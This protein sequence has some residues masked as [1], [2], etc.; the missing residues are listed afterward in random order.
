VKIRLRRVRRV[1]PSSREEDEK[2]RRRIV[3][4]ALV[5]A[6]P[7]RRLFVSNFRHNR[8]RVER[9]VSRSA[10][11]LTSDNRH[12]ITNVFLRANVS[13]TSCH[14]HALHSY[15]RYVFFPL[16]T[17]TTY[18]QLGRFDKSESNRFLR[19]RHVCAAW[20]RTSGHC[21]KQ[22]CREEFERLKITRVD[23]FQSSNVKIVRKI[24]PCS[25][26]TLNII[27]FFCR[28]NN[29]I[30]SSLKIFIIVTVMV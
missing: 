24:T 21:R 28:F 3:R 8:D 25:G 6:R 26:H 2:S 13:V 19:V 30:I 16:Q 15:A 1:W 18:G 17:L 9:A 22:H 12:S 5:S 23:L 14:T 27:N 10:P 4:S 29:Y 11:R 20:W 7:P